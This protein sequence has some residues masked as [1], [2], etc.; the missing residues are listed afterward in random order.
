MPPQMPHPPRLS[1][2]ISTPAKYN[3]YYNGSSIPELE[4][5]PF[6]KTSDALQQNGLMTL[7][8]SLTTTVKTRAR[9]RF[10]FVTDDRP[11]L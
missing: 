9:S 3:S 11:E 2:S 5:N 4:D 8:V 1:R 7:N 10:N 6:F